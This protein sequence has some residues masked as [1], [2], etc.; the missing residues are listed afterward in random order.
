MAS[1]KEY[2]EYI[3]DQLSGLEAMY[4]ELPAPGKKRRR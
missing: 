2:P 1:A 3:L 4:D